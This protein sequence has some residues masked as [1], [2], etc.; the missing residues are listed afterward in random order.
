MKFTF[1]SFIFIEIKRL[2]MLELLYYYYYFND[3]NLINLLYI[4][5]IMYKIRIISNI[6]FISNIY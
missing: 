5:L 2:K 6:K 4:D 1:K 3:I